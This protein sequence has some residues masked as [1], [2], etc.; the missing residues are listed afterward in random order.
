VACE[1]LSVQA[2]LHITATPAGSAAAVGAALYVLAV[3]E[4]DELAESGVTLLGRQAFS[5]LTSAAVGAA[6]FALALGNAHL[7]AKSGFTGLVRSTLAAACSA[8]VISAFLILA[9]G[10]A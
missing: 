2:G 9:V 6:I 10:Q 5:T 8:A 7:L 1:A 4:A 3:R